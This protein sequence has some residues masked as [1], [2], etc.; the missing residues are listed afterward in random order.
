MAVLILLRHGESLWNRENKFTGWAEAN[1]SDNGIEEAHEAGRK[2]KSEGLAVDIAFTS[3]L[4]RAIKTLWIVLEETGREWIPVKKSWKLN[5]RHY[6]ALQGLNKLEV[7]R[8]YGE[9]Q[10]KKWR[11][12]YDVRPPLIAHDDERYPGND[13][14]YAGIPESE[15]P[16]GESLKDTLLRLLPYWENNIVPELKSGKTVL[17]V[18][19]GN[20]LRAL[21]KHI[22]DISDED[23]TEIN[24]PTGIPLV[25]EFDTEMKLIS[26]KYLAAPEKLE[27]SINKVR[28]HSLQDSF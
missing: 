10:L 28:N 18:A 27:L 8:K 26:K 14:R 5:E 19:H 17:A 21:I 13:Q 23:I 11:R 7:E 15:L 16:L 4:K 1:L 12:G 6:G 2:I 9:E 22:E 3:L 24:I 20:S 25:Y